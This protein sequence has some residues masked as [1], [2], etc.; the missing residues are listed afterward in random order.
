[1]SEKEEVV[2]KEGKAARTCSIPTPAPARN[3]ATIQVFQLLAKHSAMIDPTRMTQRM[4][5]AFLR[6]SL[7]AAKLSESMPTT[8]PAD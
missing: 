5:N 3:L 2:R 4:Y 1:M 8:C 7:S 6:P